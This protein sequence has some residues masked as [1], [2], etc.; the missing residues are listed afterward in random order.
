MAP[1]PPPQKK[2]FHITVLPRKQALHVHQAFWYIILS[3]STN[4]LRRKT[5][6]HEDKFSFLFFNLDTILKNST[7]EN[8]PTF[9]KLREAK[10]TRLSFFKKAKPFLY[11]GGRGW[12]FSLPS[13]SQSLIANKI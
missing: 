6:T 9:D 7:S 2:R 4:L 8:S 5:R 12:S 11:F 10:K 1:L 3:T 13:S